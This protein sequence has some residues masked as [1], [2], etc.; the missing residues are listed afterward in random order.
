MTM[1]PTIDGEEH[2]H[3]RFEQRS[4]AGYRIVDLVIVDFG[5]LQEHFGQAVRSLRPRRSC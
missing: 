5:Y 4:E 1:V 2:D 3:D